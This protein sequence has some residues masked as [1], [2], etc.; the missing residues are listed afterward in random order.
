VDRAPARF[1]GRS[2]AAIL[3]ALFLAT[4]A[5]V[6]NSPVFD[7]RSLRVRGNSHLSAVEVRRLSGLD[8]GT[9][10]FWLSSS[11]VERR[12]EADPWIGS[13]DVS[14][15][16]PGTVILTV[17]E[18]VP[19]AVVTGTSRP[20]LLVAA[21]GTLLG[22]APDD[23]RLPSISVAL[24]HLSV[25]TRLRPSTPPLVVVLAVPQTLRS[26]VESVLVNPDG[27]VTM[28]LRGGVRVLYGDVSDALA[29]GRALLAVLSWA[30]REGITPEYVDVTAPSAPALKPEGASGPTTIPSSA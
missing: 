30:A 18:R 10:V 9:N 19:V 13:V 27:G 12:L 2:L 23:A 6:S 21:D 4:A 1:S 14:R 15:R 25:G 16:L 26:R 11:S 20:P 5:W 7:L 22:A 28:A 17:R 24:A 3:A 8:A 29:K